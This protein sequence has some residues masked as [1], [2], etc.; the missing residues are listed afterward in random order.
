MKRGTLIA[1]LVLMFGS[2]VI[3]QVFSAPQLSHDWIIKKGWF[4]D[5]QMVLQ[6]LDSSKVKE[7]SNVLR[8]NRS[9]I[10]SYS[11]YNPERLGLCGNGM[12]YLNVS[13]WEVSSNII[14][15]DVKGGR[16]ADNRFHYIMSYAITGMENGKLTLK[17]KEV[18]LNEGK[19]Y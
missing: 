2:A 11:L 1:A 5:E 7:L 17:K 4:G 12:L 16:L 6:V 13:T 3:A 14:S 18:K 15:F 10:L 9:G 8:F 19:T